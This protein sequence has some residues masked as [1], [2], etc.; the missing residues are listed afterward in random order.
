MVISKVKKEEVLRQIEAK[1][2][3]ADRIRTSL[4]YKF[5]RPEMPKEPDKVLTRYQKLS[6]IKMASNWFYHKN[7]H[8]N[9]IDELKKLPHLE[10]LENIY[11]QRKHRK[12]VYI[13]ILLKQ[14]IDNPNY[15]ADLIKFNKK[16]DIY[17]NKLK[18]RIKTIKNLKELNKQ[19]VALRASIV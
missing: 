2:L 6:K 3:A 17:K 16:K 11:L 14:Q 10:S 18:K 5:R 4:I 15:E 7:Y 13:D 19:I 9:L 12:S 1:Q 8:V